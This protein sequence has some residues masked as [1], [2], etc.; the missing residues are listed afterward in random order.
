MD[1]YSAWLNQSELTQGNF[2]IA[3]HSRPG[4]KKGCGIALMYRNQTT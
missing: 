2:A 3:M 1:E 4:D